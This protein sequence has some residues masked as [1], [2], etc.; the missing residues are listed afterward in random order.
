MADEALEAAEAV[1][2]DREWPVTVNLRFPVQF[3]SQ[4]IGTLVFRKGRAGDLRGI[5]LG[6]MPKSEQLLELAGRLCGQP[7]PVMDGLDADDTA[8]VF[9]I[10]LGFIGR[11]QSVGKKLS[12]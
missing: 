6:E 9:A 1:L 5:A 12:R 2:A 8:E 4:T 11:C 7:R 3:G 10:A